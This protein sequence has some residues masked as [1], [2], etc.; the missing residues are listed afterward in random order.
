MSGSYLKVSMCRWGRSFAGYYC[1][2]V[3][4]TFSLEAIFKAV[5]RQTISQLS[6]KTRLLRAGYCPTA[7]PRRCPRLTF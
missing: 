2:D 1:S 6:I 3:C 7:F 4:F 5:L